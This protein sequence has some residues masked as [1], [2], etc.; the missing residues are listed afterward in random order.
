[1]PLVRHTHAHTHTHTCTHTHTHTNQLHVHVH[2]IKCQGRCHSSDTHTHTHAHTHTRTHTHTRP[3]LA[4]GDQRACGVL[5][6]I[7][8]RGV[9]AHGE[10]QDVVI[11]A[12]EE[13]LRVGGLVQHNTHAGNEVDLC[14]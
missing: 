11:V 2:T 5:H 14:V 6:V 1:V 13:G 12:R 8:C 3:H 9:H 4:R 7:N 10:G